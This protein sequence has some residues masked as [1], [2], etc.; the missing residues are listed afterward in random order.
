MT[1][2]PLTT[3]SD[4]VRLYAH[5]YARRGLRVLPIRPGEKR[6]PMAAWQHAATTEAATIDAWWTGLYRDHGV[7]IATG[8]G[9][10]IFVLDVDVAGG[11]TGDETLADLC[12]R[13]GPLPET[14]T[15]ITAS[16]GQHLYFSLPK[17]T[18]VRN[19]A[20]RRLGPGLDIRGEGGQVVAP[21]TRIGDRGYEWEGGEPGDIAPAPAWLLEL[22]TTIPVTEPP[23]A[24]IAAL[25]SDTG[26][27]IAARYNA[28][29]TWGEL[30]AADGWTLARTLDDG[31]QQWTR[32]G[33]E[34]REGISA[35]TYH[36]GQDCLTVF[37]S[38]I[39]WLPEDTYSKFGYYACRHHNGDRS[40]AARALT[41]AEN[42]PADRW[43]DAL[44]VVTA[45]PAA[46]IV[47]APAPTNRLELAHLVDWGR[48]WDDDHSDEQWLAYPLAPEGRAIALYAPA[49]AGKSTIVLAVAAAVATG[50][51]ILGRRLHPLTD[52][53]YLDYEMTPA[54]LQQRLM[55]FGYGPDDDLSHLHYALLP[56]LPPLDKPEGA[57]AVME[58]LD[59]TR[60]RFVVIDTFGRAVEGEEDHADT[61]RDFYRHTGL[62]LKARGVTYL[63][64]DHSGKDVAKGM[65]GSSAKN[66]DVDIVWQLTRTDTRNGHGVKLT[67]T[68]TRVPW[69][70]HEVK[71][72][73]IDTDHGYDYVI[74]GDPRT[75]ADGTRQA[76]EAMEA[77]GVTSDMSQNKALEIV[78]KAGLDIKQKV[79]R[80]AHS[81][82]KERDEDRL[83]NRVR[84]SD[85]VEIA[86]RVRKPDA[87]APNPDAS[88]AVKGD[89]G[90]H[91]DAVGPTSD[92]V[93]ASTRVT[94]C[95]PLGDAGDAHQPD[96]TPVPPVPDL[97]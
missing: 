7:G 62:A 24:R 19:D 49:K 8:H 86:D 76:M 32:P 87:M 6:P 81:M 85:A 79:A 69:V 90:S 54:D 5:D 64:T 55:E 22:V 14:A 59:V 50:R 36:A 43:F 37:S 94:R 44:E 11:K 30:L 89:K 82:M 18:E 84:T 58:L 38:S 42:A 70:P 27:S 48:F 96:T 4:D 26:D 28:S 97:F 39:P 83:L 34:A 72:S 17:G 61:V 31:E 56:S 46:G 45:A 66:D 9:S 52:V 68:H 16:G 35:T 77:A 40:A 2:E 75:Y 29:T 74:D 95:V 23:P 53:L 15:V 12:D 25:T 73:R 92:A 33:K 51:P 10:G 1:A 41:E 93:E 47:Q 57:V 65:R 91:A 80:A 71:V 67:A 21:P 3:T 78:K 88:D 60:A 13:Y 63:R 20:G